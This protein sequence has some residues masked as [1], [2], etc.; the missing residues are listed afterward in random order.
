MIV[1]QSYTV[2]GGGLHSAATQVLKVKA[3]HR[4]V[5]IFYSAAN[6]FGTI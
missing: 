4:Y 6:V 1:T 3:R 2:G 5:H